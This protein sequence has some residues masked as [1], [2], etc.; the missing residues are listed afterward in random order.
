MQGVVLSDQ[1][2]PEGRMGDIHLLL[3][4]INKVDGETSCVCITA[5][6]EPDKIVS[7]IQWNWTEL[8]I[9][10]ALRSK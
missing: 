8:G 3:N 4:L 5:E 2:V 6:G 7:Q 1:S 9:Q 10:E